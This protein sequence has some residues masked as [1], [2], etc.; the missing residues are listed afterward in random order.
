M[1]PL[2]EFG[3]KPVWPAR[4][5]AINAAIAEMEAAQRT[6]RAAEL[7]AAVLRHVLNRVIKTHAA[8]VGDRSCAELIEFATTEAFASLPEAAAY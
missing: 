5:E 3:T 1:N 2:D 7:E 6:Q 4:N 8:V